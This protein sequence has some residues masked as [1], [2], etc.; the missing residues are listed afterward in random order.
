[1]DGV[2]LRIS[3]EAAITYTHALR[4]MH[5]AILVGVGTVL[6]DDPR[7][8][9]RLV[10]GADARPVVLD[11]MLRMPHTARLLETSAPAAVI[12]TTPACCSVAEQR[13]IT[14]GADVVRLPASASRRVDLPAL[15]TYLGERG[16]RSVMVEG[17]SRVIES[18]LRERLVDHIVVTIA[19]RYLAGKPVLPA[20]LTP[21]GSVGPGLYVDLTPVHLFWAGADLVLHADPPGA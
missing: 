5:D 7:L 6:S 4:A 17:G 13:L 19:M 21:H 3:G 14:A 2:P 9:T 15:L 11:S 20:G 16:V 8:T 18:F 10:Q 12:A 1:M